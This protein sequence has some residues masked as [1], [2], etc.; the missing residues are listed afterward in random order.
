MNSLLILSLI[1]VIGSTLPIYPV[2]AY[3]AVRNCGG[4][5]KK[6]YRNFFAIA[7]FFWF[8][9]I[10]GFSARYEISLDDARRII[11]YQACALI[12]F[13]VVATA[14]GYIATRLLEG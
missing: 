11:A 14:S 6:L 12:Q 4:D 3:L 9:S 13:I 10:S 1:L 8:Y 7:K 5:K 2:N